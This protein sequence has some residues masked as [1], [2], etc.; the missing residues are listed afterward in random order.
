MIKW[1]KLVA[2]QVVPKTA[3]AEAAAAIDSRQ[4]RA[5]FGLFLVLLFFPVCIFLHIHSASSKPF[6]MQCN[7]SILLKK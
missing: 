4:A 7:V 3:E 5:L 1:E 6:A 2:V